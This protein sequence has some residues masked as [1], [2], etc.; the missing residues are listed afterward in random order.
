MGDL[1]HAVLQSLRHVGPDVRADL[2]GCLPDLLG[3]PRHEV[4]CPDHLEC[5]VGTAAIGGCVVRLME[6]VPEQAGLLSE[7]LGDMAFGGG[8]SEVRGERH[9]QTREV[10][11]R[12]AGEV[13]GPPDGR[14]M[15]CRRQRVGGVVGDHGGKH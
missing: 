9:T 12:R 5:L 4:E 14:A 10:S 11:W 3:V 2:I 13:L 15:H 8:K 1:S 6:D 7:D